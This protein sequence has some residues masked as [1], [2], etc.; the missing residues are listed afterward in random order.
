MDYEVAKNYKYLW[1]IPAN[2][3]KSRKYA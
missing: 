2:K 1:F 3:N